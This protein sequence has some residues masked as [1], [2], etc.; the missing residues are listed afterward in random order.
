METNNREVTFVDI[1]TDGF[2]NLGVCLEENILRISRVDNENIGNDEGKRLNAFMD[3]ALNNSLKRYRVFLGDITLDEFMREG[4]SYFYCDSKDTIDLLRD[5]VKEKEEIM[6][7]VKG[8]DKITF[9]GDTYRIVAYNPLFVLA[10]EDGTSRF[11]M[12][13]TDNKKFTDTDIEM[14]KEYYD[15]FCGDA[16]KQ[17]EEK[18]A[19]L[20]IEFR[21]RTPH[22]TAEFVETGS[23]LAEFWKNYKVPSINRQKVKLPK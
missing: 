18:T 12:Q 15:H 13:R 9:F 6:R 10:K 14:A 4:D 3:K 21:L 11:V 16:V 2:Y 23:D 22:K 19:D 17:S 7:K 20:R 8:N 1:Q 5:I